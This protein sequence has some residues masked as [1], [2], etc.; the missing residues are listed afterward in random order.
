[1]I[2][3]NPAATQKAKFVFDRH[4]RPY[5]SQNHVHLPLGL[6]LFYFLS[7]FK[8]ESFTKLKALL[9][10]SEL[11]SL[12]KGLEFKKSSITLFSQFNK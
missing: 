4:C 10:H 3:Q 5:P 2:G 12:I 8:L 6:R 9:S 1:M 7:F 11:E